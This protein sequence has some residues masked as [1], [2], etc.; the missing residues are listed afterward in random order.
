MSRKIIM[1][2]NNTKF[3]TNYYENINIF[4]ADDLFFFV[5]SRV[6]RGIT[7]YNNPFA[8]IFLFLNALLN[9]R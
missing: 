2:G 6:S 9:K 5:E 4:E 3:N 8:K 7:N 1:R